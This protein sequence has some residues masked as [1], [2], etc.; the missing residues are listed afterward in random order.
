MKSGWQKIPILADLEDEVLPD[1][2]IWDDDDEEEERKQDRWFYFSTG[3]KKTKGTSEKIKKMTIHGQRY[4][5]D[6]YGRIIFLAMLTRHS[7][8]QMPT[9]RL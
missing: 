1:D 5:F 6:P 3:G 7:L 9:I 4:G 2:G 8:Q